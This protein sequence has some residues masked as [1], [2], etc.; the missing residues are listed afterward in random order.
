MKL[1]ATTTALVA[2]LSLV[3][4]A[5]DNDGEGGG[6]L[7]GLRPAKPSLDDQKAPVG[8]LNPVIAHVLDG[9]LVM[10]IDRGKGLSTDDQVSAETITTPFPI[11]GLCHACEVVV[12]RDRSVP[13][14]LNL[15]DQ[16]DQFFCHIWV[17]DAGR[18]S[19]TDCARH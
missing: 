7:T 12:L 8:T 13:N 1:L 19:S 4:C 3:G 15:L 9:G 16:Y 18:F 17:D 11:A 5:T 6:Y 14:E 2:A 10:D